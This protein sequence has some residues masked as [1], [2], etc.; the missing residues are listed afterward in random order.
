MSNDKRYQVF[1]SSTFLD[2]QEERH[3]V[4]L[5]LLQLDCFPSGM[6]LFPAANDDTLTLIQRVIAECDYYLLV[7]G[8]RYGSTDET[9]L[10][11]T[12]REYDYA[13][14]LKKPIMAFLHG[15][16]GAIPSAGSDVSAN[17]R[18]R[19]QRFRAKVEF[20]HVVKYWK[21]ADDLAGKVALSFSHFVRTYE[22]IG[23]VRADAQDSRETLA[24]LDRLRRHVA[25]LE[26]ASSNPLPGTDSLAQG[27]DEIT[28][29][30]LYATKAYLPRVGWQDMT[31]VHGV[32]SVSCNQILAA[33]GT[34]IIDPINEHAVKSL[35]EQRLAEHIPDGAKAEVRAAAGKHF[36][37]ED[38]QY[39]TVGLT[40]S[41]A[42]LDT[43]LV[44]F[45]TLGILERDRSPTVTVWRL[46]PRGVDQ[47]MRAKAIRKDPSGRPGEL[48]F[49][50]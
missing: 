18:E 23:W 13:L 2:L 34:A 29:D 15:Q 42:T 28:L 30:V 20:S 26:A 43:I 11:Y 49:H 14:S 44:H 47:L 45:M 27:D 9:G 38:L 48:T 39:G 22:A 7:I 3:A 5:A 19:L 17:A 32:L 4:T 21:N 25:E 37:A 35:L 12:E 36:G 31:A 50:D 33:L 41:A 46:T 1:I 24:E 8:G 10:S 40:M 6:E 16:P